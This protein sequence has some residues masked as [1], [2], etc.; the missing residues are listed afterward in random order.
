[1]IPSS[2][3]EENDDSELY[4]PSL[5]ELSDDAIAIGAAY[6]IPS[7]IREF[8]RRKHP[9]IHFK[10]EADIAQ[11]EQGARDDAERRY[12][13]LFLRDFTETVEY[14][15][16]EFEF[17]V[18]NSLEELI[19]S[20]EFALSGFSIL[21]QNGQLQFVPPN[22]SSL[23]QEIFNLVGD[24]NTYL[25]ER[26]FDYSLSIEFRKSTGTTIR[27]PVVTAKQ[28]NSSLFTLELVEGKYWSNEIFPFY[29]KSAS[30]RSK[31]IHEKLFEY[32]N[33][34]SALVWQICIAME[35]VDIYSK[36]Q[37][38][39]AKLAG[40]TWV[41]TQTTRR[42]EDP[43]F[44]EFWNL[45][46]ERA[47]LVQEEAFSS[48]YEKDR[49]RYF[50]LVD[51]DPIQ[52]PDRNIEPAELKLINLFLHTSKILELLET[53]ISLKL[54]LPKQLH[55]SQNVQAVVDIYVNEKFE[56]ALA[57]TRHWNWVNFELSE[58]NIREV[59]EAAQLSRH[60]DAYTLLKA[61]TKDLQFNQF[62]HYEQYLRLEIEYYEKQLRRIL[63]YVESPLT[64]ATQCTWFLSNN[65][66]S[67]ESG[68]YQDEVKAKSIESIYLTF[69]DRFK[70]STGNNLDDS[71]IAAWH[72][73]YA[74]D[75]K[76]EID[77]GEHQSHFE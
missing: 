21:E 70:N 66:R 19:D 51:F 40:S 71:D 63:Q 30:K 9:E 31:E 46:V 1:M 36:E 2:F 77:I 34:D 38:I 8:V 42:S 73:S 6:G 44:E 53:D 58:P 61:A 28:D 10:T 49:R 67:L 48:H 55:L 41:L 43:F 15:R 3:F 12:S 75:M 45:A 22:M 59:D 64:L 74:S 4:Q 39:P 65:A 37:V 26:E 60:E 23:E 25:S 27:R 13:E 17:E 20:E 32:V 29:L 24:A 33:S 7:H 72:I 5:S 56:A 62:G 47:E 68:H 69:S 50:Q 16:A 35:I 18:P 76:V 52:Q 54:H 14:S 57:L 11:E